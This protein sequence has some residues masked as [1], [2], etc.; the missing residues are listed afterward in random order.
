[1]HLLHRV[2][3]LCLTLLFTTLVTVLFTVNPRPGFMDTPTGPPIQE[4]KPFRKTAAMLEHFYQQRSS[5]NPGVN[6]D[7]K[8][9]EAH[10]IVASSPQSAM[11]KP[12]AASNTWMLEGPINVG[13]RMRAVAVHP[14]ETNT[15]LA[16]GAAGGV[17]RSTDLGRTWIPLSDNQPRLAVGAVAIDK[18]NPDILF[19]GTGE[20]I[21]VNFGRSNGSPFYDGVGVIRSSDGGQSWALLPWPS[22]SSAVHRIA[23]NPVSSDTLLVATI[24]RLFKSTNGGQNWVNVLSGVITDVMYK[25]GDPSTVYAAVGNNGGGSANGVYVSTSGGD[26]FTWRK[27]DVNFAPGD[28]CGRIVMAIPEADPN[29]IYAAVALNRALLASDDADF[30]GVFVSTNGGESWLRKGSAVPNNF[31]RGQAYYDLC[32]AASPANAND[33]LLGGIDMFRS[34]NGGDGFAKVSRWELRTTDGSNP[35]YVHADQHHITF[36]PDE[37]NVVIVGND[38]G[39]FIS[40]DGGNNWTERTGNLATTQFYSITY[41]PSNPRLLYGGTQDNSNLR[42][43]LPGQKEWLFVGGGD[44]GRLAVDPLRSDY[45]YFN[46]NSTPFRTFDGGATYEYIGNGLNNQ[47]FNWIRPMALSADNKRLYTAS[48]QINYLSEPE[49]GNTWRKIDGVLASNN[50]IVTDIEIVPGQI[51]KMF[52]SS[53]TGDVYTTDNL[54]ALDVEWVNISGNLPKRWITDIH[55]DWTDSRTLYVCFSGYGIGHAWRTTNLG[56][57]WENI[58]GDLP[59]IP[60]NSIIPSRTEPNTIFLAT[61]LGVWYTTNGGTNWKQFGNGLPNVVCYDMKLTPL[62]TLVVGTF[63]RGIWSTDVTVTSVQPPVAASDAF[64]TLNIAPNPVRSASAQLSFSLAASGS[65]RISIYDASGRLVSSA[66][67]NRYQSGSHSTR[68]NTSG[69]RAGSYFAVL[70]SGGKRVTSKFAVLK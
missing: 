60:A 62:N 22:S 40:S 3:A 42:Q 8:L 39:V 46:M 32:I 69:L 65:I 49:S 1:M 34:T 35:A 64:A 12:F 44:G 27:L 21:S 6:V 25:P 33:V 10:A 16:G 68:L 29:R 15:L 23:L 59:D 18:N 14:T 50:G 5:G 61:D 41:A 36:K 38:G 51:R 4:S 26:R 37:P 24:D 56:E 2:P 58:S 67:E 11:Y 70:E 30:K 7:K 57:S 47:R 45:F 48:N 52:T 31:T 53:S 17:W 66:A 19:A 13:G 28:S 20:P 54:I 43:S 63:G 55:L 9:W